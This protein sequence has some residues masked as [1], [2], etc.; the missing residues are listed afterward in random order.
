MFRAKMLLH[1]FSLQLA[2]TPS[3]TPSSAA[4]YL[5]RRTND[6]PDFWIVLLRGR[7][8]EVLEPDIRYCEVALLPKKISV[9]QST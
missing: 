8:P 6:H 1:T 5:R 2:K 7:A 9:I 4:A 3:K